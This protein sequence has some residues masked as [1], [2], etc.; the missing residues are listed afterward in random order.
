VE[1]EGGAESEQTRDANDENTDRTAS[2]E[3]HRRAPAVHDDDYG[4]AGAGRFGGAQTGPGLTTG[5][6]SP[7]T[8]R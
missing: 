2:G 3:A 7:T 5:A 8:P 4:S 1:T 6:A